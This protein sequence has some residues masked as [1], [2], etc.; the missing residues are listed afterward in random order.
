[1]QG[2]CEKVEEKLREV[3]ANNMDLL[4][5]NSNIMSKQ[6]EFERLQAEAE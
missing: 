6:T 1:M 4:K 2:R 3:E 5:K